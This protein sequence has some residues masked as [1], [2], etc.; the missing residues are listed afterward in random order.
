VRLCNQFWMLKICVDLPCLLNPYYSVR[1]QWWQG[2]CVARSLK[3]DI[4][5]SHHL[6]EYVPFLFVHLQQSLLDLLINRI[7]YMVFKIWKGTHIQVYFTDIDQLWMH[8]N[9]ERSWL[10]ALVL[11]YISRKLAV[12]VNGK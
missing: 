8:A 9:N 12:L 5:D 11:S 1:N 4:L 7:L 2:N 10:V 3:V 6:D